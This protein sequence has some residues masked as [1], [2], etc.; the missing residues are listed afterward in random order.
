MKT[1]K[2]LYTDCIE[3]D[4][5]SGTYRYAKNI[6]DSNV[7]GVIENEDGFINLDEITPYTVIGIIPVRNDF[8]V[9]STDNVDS[10]IGVVSRSGSTLTYTLVYNDPE[11]NFSTSAPI[12]GEFRKDVTNSRVV[13]WIDDINSPRILNIDDL[14]DIDDIS[15]LDMFPNINNPALSS[16]VINDTGGSLET[17][18]YIPITQ[19]KKTDG[20]TTNWFVH[21]HTFYINDDSKSVAFNENDGA[22]PNTISNKSFTFSLTDCDTNFVTLVVGYI[23]SVDN[24][25]TAYQV[26]EVTNNTTVDLTI[27]GNESAIDISLDEILTPTAVYTSAKAITQLASRLYLANLTSDDL[28]DLQAVALDIKID[29]VLGD[30]IEVISNTDNHK[31]SLPPTFMPGEVYAFYL[32]I[33]LKKGGWV[34][35]HIPGR[36][37]VDGGGADLERTTVVNEGLTYKKFQVDSTNDN[38]SGYSN[39]GYWEN[40]GELYPDDPSFVGA[41]AGDLRN[42]PVRHHRFPTTGELVQRYYTADSTVGIT[43][44]PQLGITVSNVIIPSGIQSQITRWK[45]F[46][47]K[48][49]L[50]DSL[51]LGSDIAQFGCSSP[52][53]PTTRY[54]SGG[55]WKTHKEDDEYLLDAVENDTLRIHSLDML[56]NTGSITPTYAAFNY[57]LRRTNLNDKWAGFRASGGTLIRTGIY[58]IGDDHG[59][60]VSGT[61]VDYTTS[62]TTTRTDFTPFIKRLDNFRYVPENAISNEANTQLSEGVFTATINNPGTSFNSL[63]FPSLLLLFENNVFF[64]PEYQFIASN[65]W[66]VEAPD[67]GYEETMGIQYFNLLTAVHNS[68]NAQDLRPTEGYAEPGD[69]T[70][71]SIFGGDAFA[72]YM[73]YLSAAPRSPIL[74]SFPEE[75]PST[76]IR[77]WKA[78]IGYSRY[79]FNYRYQDA[80]DITTYYHGK[81]KVGTLFSVTIPETTD[82]D[83]P[84]TAFTIT[85]LVQ[86]NGPQNVIKYTEDYNK[87][88]IFIIGVIAHPNLINQT[89]F[90]NTIIYSPVQN[91]ETKEFAWGGFRAGDRFVTAKHRGDIIN[92]QEFKN[93]QLIIHTEDSFFRTRTDIKVGAQQEDVFFQTGDLFELPPEEPIP[94]YGG[95]QHKFGCVLTKMGYIFPDDKQGKVFL[96]NGEALEEISSNGMRA[97]FRD[98]MN[99]GTTD[100]PFTSDGYTA[101]YDE[102][103]NRILITKKKGATSWTISYN[104]MKKTWT[105]YHDYIPDYMFKTADNSLYTLKDN[106]FYLNN[107]VPNLVQ[108]GQFYGETIYPSFIDVVYVGDPT[109]DKQFGAVKWV[110][111]CY[112]VTS[113]DGQV[114]TEL[115]YNNTCTHLTLRSPDHCTGKMLLVNYIELDAFYTTNI[116]NITRTWYFDDIRDYVISDGFVKGFYDDFDIDP[117]KLNTNMEWY[118]QRKFTDKY[119]I[120]R[121]EYDNII[122]NRFLFLESEILYRNAR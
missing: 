9:F 94:S 81:T 119:V 36:P 66:G 108:K 102:R 60:R 46:Y 78:Y 45:I 121:F 118:D 109:M 73:S 18:A 68:F 80:G 12:Q 107:P 75:G 14:S 39:M 25:L 72:C 110:T 63:N 53:S 43:K 35:Y 10:E 117:L 17:G 59:S 38:G 55:N 84:L 95:T 13:A 65:D 16:P 93:K 29:Y 122:N 87:E 49:D 54:S 28:P 91:E 5:P 74:T 34:Y 101:G 115:N 105:S 69:T 106:T 3:K 15:D 41:L 2:G 71:I 116:R 88:N 57:K 42:E 20:S 79:N 51:V 8:V 26:A 92:I 104:P 24:I 113:T 120:C 98:F 62:S 83:E 23:K 99:L 100:N 89:E 44:L 61:V 76:G 6:V 37:P 112:P 7:L 67:D 48:K 70:K 21:D 33:E 103:N 56:F 86:T 96:Y 32:G 4:Q 52:G 77:S 47:A 40:E 64:A 111:E 82:W 11:L 22:E 30:L 27:T 50:S 90:P 1:D 58:P 114:S 31:D 19:Y 85:S 97:F